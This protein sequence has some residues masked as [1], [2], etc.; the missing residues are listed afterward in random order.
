[1]SIQAFAEQH[2][3]ADI[4]TPYTVLGRYNSVTSRKRRIL[5]NCTRRQGGG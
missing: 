5:D 3:E 2:K 4:A 1:M